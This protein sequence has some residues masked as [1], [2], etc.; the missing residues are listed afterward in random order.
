MTY[1]WSEIPKQSLRSLLASGQ[2][3]LCLICNAPVLLETAKTDERG[4]AIHEECYLL[5]VRLQRETSLTEA[6]NVAASQGD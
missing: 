5:K 4:N 1:P 3:P 6:R 2:T